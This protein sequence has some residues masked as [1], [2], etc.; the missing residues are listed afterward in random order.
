MYGAKRRTLSPHSEQQPAI[1]APLLPQTVPRGRGSNSPWS[2]RHVLRERKT[3]RHVQ[4]RSAAPAGDGVACPFAC[5]S[6]EAISG[7]AVQ[8]GA[9]RCRVKGNSGAMLVH[10]ASESPSINRHLC[11]PPQISGDLCGFF[12][13][14]KFFV[15]DVQRSPAHRGRLSMSAVQCVRVRGDCSRTNDVSRRGDLALRGPVTRIVATSY[16]RVPRRMRSP[17][18]SLAIGVSGWVLARAQL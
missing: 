10:D 2:A 11:R 13:R 14:Q 17:I 5:R 4:D 12:R 9:L 6:H 3:L 15:V 8:I 1:V 18:G 7:E 16:S